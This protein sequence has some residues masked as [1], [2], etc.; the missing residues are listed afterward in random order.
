MANNIANLLKQFKP[1]ATPARVADPKVRRRET[2]MASVREQLTLLDNPQLQR[3]VKI[4]GVEQQQK[5][6]PWFFANSEGV[7]L[8]P[9]FGVRALELAP[10]CTALRIGKTDDLRKALE[11]LGAAAS[12]GELD[13]A[14]DAAL[15]KSPGRTAKR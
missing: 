14:L 2:F 11:A 6:R 8:A 15:P 4:K 3:T 7:V 13:A 9:K 10:G 12:A 5:I 1:I